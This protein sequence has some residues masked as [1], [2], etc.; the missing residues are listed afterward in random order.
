MI[1]TS[2]KVEENIESATQRRRV[3][4]RFAVG[5]NIPDMDV[6]ILKFENQSPHGHS[7]PTDG[8]NQLDKSG[9]EMGNSLGNISPG[10]S[11]IQSID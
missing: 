7:G 10:G 2:F 9:L 3:E 1:W 4:E 11:H 5:F 6:C 8:L